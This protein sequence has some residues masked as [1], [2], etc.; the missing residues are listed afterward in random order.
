MTPRLPCINCNRPTNT[1]GAG[2]G[3]CARCYQYRRRNGY[4]PP[5][6]PVRADPGEGRYLLRLPEELK[7]KAERQAEKDGVGLAEWIR[8]LMRK[9]LGI[10]VGR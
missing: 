6:G 10:E 5:P 1:S 2:D 9:A 7:A 8:A 3:L 4:L